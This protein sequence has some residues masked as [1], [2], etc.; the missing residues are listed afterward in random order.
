MLGNFLETAPN[1]YFWAALGG[2]LVA[3]PVFWLLAQFFR[4]PAHSGDMVLLS[5]DPASWI[6]SFSI[7]PFPS[8]LPLP[9]EAPKAEAG[10]PNGRTAVVMPPPTARGGREKREALRR[11]GNPTAVQIADPQ[12]KTIKGWVLNR[13]TKGLAVACAETFDVG[14]T[15]SLRSVQYGTSGPWVHAQV[16][17]CDPAQEG[18]VI[19]CKFS[20]T[21]PWNV[22]LLFG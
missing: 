6:R 17:R 2:S 8:K 10:Q 22:L 19:G 11:A 4:R 14:S 5:R 20:E 21:L 18:W 1:W 3:L 12:G 9:P 16:R 15:I 13:S 7:T